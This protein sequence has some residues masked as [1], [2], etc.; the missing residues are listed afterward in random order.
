MDIEERSVATGFR[1]LVHL[2][3]PPNL[4]MCQDNQVRVLLP[5]PIASINLATLFLASASR[6]TMF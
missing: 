2:L 6:R 1:Y 4:Q 5:L 3:S